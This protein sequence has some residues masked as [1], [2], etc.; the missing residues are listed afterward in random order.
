M[1]SEVEESLTIKIR[2]VSTALDVTA[3][4]IKVGVVVFIF[5]CCALPLR[6]DQ[7]IAQIQ[8]AL[9]EQGF[10]YGEINGEKNADTTAA[11]RRFQIRSGLQVTGD[12]NDETTKA[13]RSVPIAATPP[14]LTAATTP[15]AIANTPQPRE[16]TTEETEPTAPAPPQQPYAAPPQA[17]PAYPK[18]PSTG[19]ALPAVPNGRPP[20]AGIFSYTPYEAAPPEVQR[21][22][23]VSAQRALARRGFYHGPADGVYGSAMEFSLR[24][25]QARV[26]LPVTG[27]LDLETLAALE[28]L[29]GAHAPVYRPRQRRVVPRVRGEWIRP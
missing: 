5:V 27:R 11:I 21:D 2:D 26:R 15:P 10:Y 8:Q 19:P 25:Y 17:E 9:K 28:L 14:P 18:Y 20:P 16:Q 13:L 12:L 7:Q 24:A 23:L 22:V 1:P 6:A 4:A 3:H 29:P